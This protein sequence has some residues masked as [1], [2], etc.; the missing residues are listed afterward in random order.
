M[1]Y[2]R[3][4]LVILAS[5][6]AH[7]LLPVNKLARTSRQKLPIYAEASATGSSLQG[8]RELSRAGMTLFRQGRVQESAE[9]F[10]KV[11]V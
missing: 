7:G 11:S 6:C 9:T 4:A 8:P 1:L 2:T 10:D 5:T 3:G